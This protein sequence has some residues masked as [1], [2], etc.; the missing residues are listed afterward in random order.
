ME[1]KTHLHLPTTEES[2]IVERVLRIVS[3][4]RG[5]K[6][7]YA[8]LAAELEPAIPF[9]VFGIVLLRHDREAVRIIACER[10]AGSWFSNYHQ[11]PLQGSNVEQLLQQI[12]SSSAVEPLPKITN[13]SHGLDGLPTQCGDALSNYHQLRS[14]CIAPLIVEGRL[15]GTLELGS[16]ELHT[17]DEESLRRLLEGVVRVIATAIE[18]AQVGG[19]VEIQNRQRQAL[20]D[21]SSALTSTMD[22]S[23]ILNKIVDGVVQALNVPSAIVMLNQRDGSLRVEAQQG[24]D[25]ALFRRLMRQKTALREHSII[26]YSLLTRQPCVSQDIAVDA[27]FTQN[28]QFATEL[29]IHSIY[30]YPLVTGTVVYG[31]LLLCS[32]EP[33]G[34]TPLKIEILSLFASQATI[35]IHNGMLVESAHQRSRFQEA[36]EQLE[37]ARVDVGDENEAFER[38]LWETESTFGIRF[39]SLVRFISD[40]LLTRSEHD[41]RMMLSSEHTSLHEP[42]DGHDEALEPADASVEGNQQERAFVP[43]SQGESIALLT[44]TAEAALARVAVMSELGGLLMQLQQT[45]GYTN[46]AWFVTDPQ[47]HYLSMNASAELFCGMRN[48]TIGVGRETTL[49]DIFAHL[50]PRIRDKDTARLYLGEFVQEGQEEQAWSEQRQELRCVIALN[51]ESVEN[52]SAENNQSTDATKH[53]KSHSQSDTAPTDQYYQLMR[54]PLYNAQGLLVGRALLVHDITTQIRDEKNK[55]ALLTSVSHDLRT[56]LTTIKAAVTGLMGTN[57]TWDEATY[58][59]ILA[60]IN[61]ESDHLEVLVTD[62]IEM[63]RIE[64]GALVL[65]NEWCD[66]L[67]VLYR[68]VARLESVVGERKILFQTGSAFQAELPLL[69]ADHVQLERAFFYLMEY[70]AHDTEDGV[71]ILAHVEAVEIEQVEHLRVQIIDCGKGMPVGERERIFKTF[72]RPATHGNGHPYGSGLGLAI[73]R[74]IVDAHHGQIYVEALSDDRRRACFT[75]VLPLHHQ[76]GIA[77]EHFSPVTHLSR[78]R[79]FLP[80]ELL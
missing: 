25:D 37:Q 23:L 47:G 15:L 38:V 77:I 5:S 76:N 62:L 54:Y 80:E 29:G 16:T 73:C 18:G 24:L 3:S 45:T 52:T 61:T 27:R 33:G 14:T 55:A 4:V 78:K 10:R 60:D 20:R 70:V 21:V 36:I 79:E 7:D 26:G 13:Y 19:S 1:A 12:S 72:Y 34:F 48:D 8:R 67:E 2:I 40:H 65:E 22:L 6:P 53:A 58:R 31:T 74:G 71:E 56:P 39:S 66:I 51:A 64:M 43:L 63:S 9:D 30:S 57:M 46:D 50:L 41:L 44:H 68:A 49:E 32:R 75:C 35:A 11:H 59:E 69:Y 28:R 42:V 17:Y